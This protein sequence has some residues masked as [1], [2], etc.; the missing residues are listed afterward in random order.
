MDAPKTV[1]AN[2]TPG[3]W[4]CISV[5]VRVVDASTAAGAG[6]AVVPGGET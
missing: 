3:D 1:G 2:D 6:W 4:P 5:S